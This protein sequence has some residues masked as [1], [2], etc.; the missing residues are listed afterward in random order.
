MIIFFIISIAVFTAFI[1]FGV[2]KYGIP[3]SISDIYYLLPKKVNQPVFWAWSVLTAVPLLVFWLDLTEATNTQFLAF[4]SCSGLLFVGTAAAFKESF[5]RTVHITAA[6]GC[7]LFGLLW[8]AIHPF[9]WILPIVIIILFTTIGYKSPHNKYGNH[10]VFFLELAAFLSTYTS[11]YA[12]Y[13][14]H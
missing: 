7:A 4:L 5:T 3:P 2:L 14:I 11:I 1:T 12:Y 6:C 9:L 8:I 13:L 10:L